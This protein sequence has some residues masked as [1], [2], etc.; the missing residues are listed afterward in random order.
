MR[1]K[2]DNYEIKTVKSDKSRN[3]EIKNYEKV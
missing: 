1:I 2:I 3:Y